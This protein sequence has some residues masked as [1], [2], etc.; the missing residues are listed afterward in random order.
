MTPGGTL[1]AVS[2]RGLAKEFPGN[3]APAVDDVSFDVEHGELLVLL[4]PSGCG[5]TTTLRMIAGLEEPD[6][7]EVWLG[8]GLVSSA[9]RNVFV[10]TEKRNIGMVFQ[11]YAIW[12]H[13]TVFENVAY[14]LR[15]R[16]VSRKLIQERVGQT[17]E[18]L[19]L[20]GLE[21]RPA[22][23]LSGGQQ[24]RVALARALVFEPRILLLDEPLSNLDAKLRV[25][26]RSELKNLQQA[27]GI[28]SIFV[29]H[30]QAESMAL[31]DR[32]I[33]MNRGRIEQIGSPADVYQR[34]RSRFVND[35]VGSMNALQ[36]V[37]VDVDGSTV[38]LRCGEHEVRGHAASDQQLARGDA[39]T[40]TM[41]PENLSILPE[42]V[43]ASSNQW[44][45]CVV[46]AAYYGDHREY[47]V[48]I[49][50]QS[51]TLSAPASID[52]PRGARVIVTCDPSEVVVIA[53]S[54]A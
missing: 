18:L 22:T 32:I 21:E 11:S 13:M 1:S 2:C 47:Q 24:Q 54:L 45:A 20:A 40:A 14:P 36:G 33:V 15:V 30:D 48:E 5:K 50:E 25:H 38:T 42:S 3:P 28:T 19:G 31:A 12:P 10:P 41:R 29:T 51:V 39:V 4:G 37:V 46:G 16:R 8:S 44:T 9:Q 17:L 23:Q 34:P 26:M 27:T 53:D 35:F 43:S 52:V 7:G 6:A 49:G